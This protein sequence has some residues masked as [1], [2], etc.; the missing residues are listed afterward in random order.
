MKTMQRLTAAVLAVLILLT[1]CACGAARGRTDHYDG[2]T[3]R[4]EKSA[5]AAQTKETDAPT[6]GSDNDTEEDYVLNRSSKKFHYPDCTGAAEIKEHNRWEYHGT[7]QSV[8][9]MGYEPC[10][11]CN[12]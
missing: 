4:T 7:R 3:V 10:K 9:D 11:I 5:Q 8:L 2:Y 12:P 1:L 6:R